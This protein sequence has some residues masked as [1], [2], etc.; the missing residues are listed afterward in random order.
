[1]KFEEELN[2]L[3]LATLWRGSDEVA[4]HPGVIG[5]VVRKCT[6]NDM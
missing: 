2:K 1:M 6:H 5:Y 4:H 3:E